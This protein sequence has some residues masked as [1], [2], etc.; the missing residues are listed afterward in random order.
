[1]ERAFALR[2]KR[3]SDRQA[4]VKQ[5]YD[6]QWRDACDDARTLDS[7]AMDKY[8]G[9]DRLAMIQEK[10]R[11]KQELSVAENRW[12]EE[13]AKHSDKLEAIEKAKDDSRAQAAL[14]LQRGL[15]QQVKQIFLYQ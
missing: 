13:Y 1:M 8:V 12:L 7:K 4:F 2:D 15:R 9:A 5:C 3:E 6:A 10:Q 14:D 11:R